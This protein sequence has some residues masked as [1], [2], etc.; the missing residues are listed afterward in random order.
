MHITNLTLNTILY[1]LHT[2]HYTNQT[3][4]YTMYTS[5]YALILVGALLLLTPQDPSCND[6]QAFQNT[7][8]HIV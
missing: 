5:H 7:E 2:V 4:H 1:K 3:E 6:I 8:L